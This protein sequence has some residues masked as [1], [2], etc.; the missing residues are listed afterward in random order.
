M[1]KIKYGLLKKL[2]FMQVTVVLLGGVA[3]FST[4]FLSSLMIAHK[5]LE[6]EKK[7]LSTK[8]L[9]RLDEWTAWY[10][11]GMNDLL[12]EELNEFKLQNHLNKLTFQT[13][14]PSSVQE[15]ELVLQSIPSLFLVAELKKQNL[16]EVIYNQ[17]D[18]IFS[19]SCLT[20]LFM[21]ISYISFIYLRKKVHQPI[22]QL[23]ESM[24]GNIEGGWK[25]GSYVEASDEMRIFV[26]EIGFL[27]EKNKL[28]ERTS[29]LGLI[30]AQVSHDLIS[31]ISSLEVLLENCSVSNEEKELLSISVSRIKTIADDLLDKNRSLSN[32]NSLVSRDVAELIVLKRSEFSKRDIELIYSENENCENVIVQISTLNLQRAL[33]NII[34][35]AA[36][37]YEMQPGRIEVCI[38]IKENFLVI[39]VK[40]YGRGLTAE[41]LNRIGVFGYTA[42]K[43]KGSGIGLFSAKQLLESIGG[44]LDITSQLG[45]GTE[46]RLIFPF[47]TS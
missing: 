9:S 45:I 37:A 16:L 29:A 22:I 4:F 32:T 23:I 11:V 3:I 47:R 21:L 30:T 1:K 5:N 25:G 13:T 24:N 20:F 39:S 6:S 46:V 10:E 38:F 41:M 2:F 7:E 33:S 34:N 19:I 17:K 18:V 26:D 28:M 15:N 12:S 14:T 42:N 31:P 8:L 44:K 35:N 43:K 27:F 40:D 36:E